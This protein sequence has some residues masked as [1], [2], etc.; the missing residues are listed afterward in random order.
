MKERIVYKQEEKHYVSRTGWL[1]AAVL[2]AN[3]GIISVTSLVV[4]VAAAAVGSKEIFISGIAGLVS[5]AMSMA[6]GEYVSVSSQ[7]DLEDA[8]LTRE[9]NEL[10]ETPDKELEELAEIYTGRGVEPK[11]AY[12][13][14]KQMMA[15]NALE[16][17]AR[18]ELGITEITIAKPLQ[19]AIASAISFSCGSL[20]PLLSILFFQREIFIIA[21]S[22]VSILLLG[23]L[24]AI[25][26]KIGGAS[27][28]WPAAR[29][30]FWG[31]IAMGI[32]ALIGSLFG[33]QPA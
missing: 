11:L 21:S 7:A 1:R 30:M 3:D 19:A 2:G 6:A 5:G 16:T 23:V 25:A 22:S 31:A 20:V 24:G 14:A 28:L 4:G 8:D 29:I 15:K 26:A 13:V 32:T 18:D 10:V 17:H 27:I 33:V 12:E 9:K